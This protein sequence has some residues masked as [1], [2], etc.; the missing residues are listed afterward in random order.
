MKFLKR[1]LKIFGICILIAS[2]FIAARIGYWWFYEDG[3][4]YYRYTF[5][6]D[7][8]P[9][10]FSDKTSTDA[11]YSEDELK[12][13]LDEYFD[14]EVLDEMIGNSYIIPGLR[15][16]RTISSNSDHYVSVCTS[17]TPQGV[18]MSDDYV[19]ISAYCQLQ[20]HNSVIYMIDRESHA[21]IKEI[22]LPDRSHVGSIAYDVLHDNLWVCCYEEENKVA[23]VCSLKINTVKNYDF[24]KT[25][26]PIR[27]SAQYPIDTMKRSSFMNYYNGSLYVGYFRSSLQS[28]S[29]VQEFT[30]DSNGDLMYTGN[31]MSDI[32]D[33]EPDSYVLPS[34]MFYI[35]G[36]AQGVA[37]NDK[38]IYITQ[39]HGSDSDSHL[40]VF[41][42][43]KDE[44]GNV[45]AQDENKLY[46]IHLPCM[47]EDCHM[48]DDG[49][50]YLCFESAAYAYRARLS[51]H[52]DRIIFLPHEFLE[53]GN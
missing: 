17:M 40:L 38:D 31:L 5:H 13:M 3:E 42:N 8:E 49:N 4:T 29:T 7:H 51:P 37:L 1:I 19:F 52:I 28:Q 32:Y 10:S 9:F 18:T 48:D 34:S 6:K 2:L 46:S 43:K 12:D 44:D 36:L 50:L 23:F 33:D 35:N 39:S 27:Y 47:A 41:Q 24:D 14:E 45:N 15:S 25:Y 30:I 53:D 26:S 21:F 16:T 20:K 22:V 11:L